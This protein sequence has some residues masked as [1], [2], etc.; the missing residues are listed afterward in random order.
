MSRGNPFSCSI[1]ED[2]KEWRV[3]HLHHEARIQKRGKSHGSGVEDT[4][5]VVK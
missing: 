1:C 4:S 3:G 5:Q 2:V